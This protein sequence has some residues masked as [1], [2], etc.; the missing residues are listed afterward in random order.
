MKPPYFETKLGQLFNDDCL[1]VINEMGP[2]DL[3][4]TSPPYNVGVNYDVHN[5]LM[6]AKD[7]FS[8]IEEVFRSLYNIMKDDSRLALNLPYEVNFKDIG[9]GRYF[10]LGEYW[11]ILQ[12]IGFKWAGMIDLKETSAHRPK[13]TSWGSWLSPS[14]PYVY[15]PKECVMLLYKNNWKKETTGTSYFHK[16]NKNEFIKYVSGEW[17]YRAETK[18][19]TEANFS[20]DIPLK[21]L[22]LLSWQEDLVYDPFMGSG[23]TALAC[24][25]LGRR[26]TGSEISKKYC[27]VARDRLKKYV[28][29][30]YFF[31]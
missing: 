7:Y 3:V 28:A 9:D 15:N 5:D 20:L 8:W 19:L 4:I 18:G 26:W 27:K 23:T 25:M 2:P 30:D 29:C 16:E 11:K 13:L 22:K 10:L 24:E 21:A 14:A 12:H 17:K 31:E 1:N 6:P